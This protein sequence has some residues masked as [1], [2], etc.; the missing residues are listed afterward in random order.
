MLINRQPIQASVI[1]I[2]LVSGEEIIAKSVDETD[3]TYTLSKPLTLMPSQQGI[4]LMQT[5]IAMNPEAN[6]TLHK[7][8]VAFTFE[9]VSEIE[10]HY[11]QTTSGIAIARV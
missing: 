1:G 10:A 8:A 9:V 7:S 11:T 6:V 4:S 2:K 3:A 5:L